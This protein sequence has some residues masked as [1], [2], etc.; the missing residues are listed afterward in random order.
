MSNVGPCFSVTVFDV[1]STMAKGDEGFCFE[2]EDSGG[3]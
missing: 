1:L 2:E 3:R